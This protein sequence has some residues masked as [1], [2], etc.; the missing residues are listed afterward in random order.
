MAF[1]R[2]L[3]WILLPILVWS[4]GGAWIEGERRL[5]TILVCAHDSVA[6]SASCDPA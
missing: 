5:Q 1:T 6:V 4:V 3:G 2:Y